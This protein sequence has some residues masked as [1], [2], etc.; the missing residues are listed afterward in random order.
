MLRLPQWSRQIQKALQWR[1]DWRNG[2]IDPEVT[3]PETVQFVNAVI[4]LIVN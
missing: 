3:Y 4:D 1:K 2:D